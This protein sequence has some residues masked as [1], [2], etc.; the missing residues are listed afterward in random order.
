MGAKIIQCLS[1]GDGATVGA[2]AVVLED[3]PEGATVVG[4]PAR[5]V[6]T[7]APGPPAVAMT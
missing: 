6:K 7:A 5:V 2:G 4:V 1:V 3:V